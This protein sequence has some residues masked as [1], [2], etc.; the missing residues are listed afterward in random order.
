MTGAQAF[1][2][3]NQV[4]LNMGGSVI[5]TPPKSP[6]LT[7]FVAGTLSSAVLAVTITG[8]VNP[9]G[10][11]IQFLCCKPSAG[12]IG[13]FGKGKVVGQSEIGV[14]DPIDLGPGITAVWGTLQPGCEL[15]ILQVPVVNGQKFPSV[16]TNVSYSGVQTP[17]ENDAWVSTGHA[18]NVT[19]TLADPSVSPAFF[20][21]RAEL[22]TGGRWV[23]SDPAAGTDTATV[24]TDAGSTS[25]QC[26]WGA[27]STPDSGWSDWSES[28]TVVVTGEGLAKPRKH[29]SS[30]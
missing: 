27:S 13:F 18:G 6:N 15:Q 17:P 26:R 5:L 12:G 16:S 29:K 20:Q 9:E 7:N 22:V 23:N 14:S 30:Q 10:G 1:I 2:G 24:D 21:I 19:G 3:I 28:Q 8:Y 4:A 11:Q 25:V